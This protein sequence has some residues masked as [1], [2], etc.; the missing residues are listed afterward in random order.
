M[1]KSNTL[2]YVLVHGGDRDGSIWRETASYLT[3]QGCYVV[4]PSMTT[5][6]KA[7]V[8][9][10][11]NEVIDAI[12]TNNI[13]NCIL[14]GHSYGGFV[15]TG[16]ADRLKEKIKAIVYVDALIPCHG[17]SLY[18]RAMHYQFDY[19][20]YGLTLDKAVMS[21][22]SFRPEV[23]FANKP[24]AYISCLRS[25]FIE[26]IRPMYLE[27]KKEHPDWLFYALD[28]EHGCMFTHPKELAAIIYGMQVLLAEQ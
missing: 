14:V 11:I 8:E 1:K 18:D 24:I 23:V 16:V 2:S 9:E 28:S 15:V 4:T 5:V 26:L 17:Q 22:I 12:N 13:N 6:T 27:A 25:E 21:K 7:T 3:Q 19:K 20:K 10:N